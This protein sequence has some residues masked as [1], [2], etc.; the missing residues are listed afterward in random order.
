MNAP[1]NHECESMMTSRKQHL[2]PTTS[3]TVSVL[4]CLHVC[5]QEPPTWRRPPGTCIHHLKLL[6]NQPSYQMMSFISSPSRASLEQGDALSHQI[7]NR[8]DAS[9]YVSF[10]TTTTTT[11]TIRRKRMTVSS[12]SHASDVFQ[13]TPLLLQQQQLSSWQ[14]KHMPIVT[15]QHPK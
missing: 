10:P 13:S 9:K 3:S 6:P 8:K 15:W 11:T 14:E 7:I 5:H 1:S 12:M 2:P 4:L